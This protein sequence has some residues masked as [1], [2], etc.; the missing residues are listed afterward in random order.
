MISIS[1]KV[2]RVANKNTVSELVKSK[3]I[4]RL[5]GEKCLSVRLHMLRGS[6]KTRGVTSIFDG[7][8]KHTRTVRYG[9]EK[10]QKIKKQ[11]H[12]RSPARRYVSPS[13]F[14]SRTH[15]PLPA[16]QDPRK[17][18]DFLTDQ[19]GPRFFLR[20]FDPTVPFGNP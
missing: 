9:R 3:K 6:R 8:R 12:Y 5:P 4:T 10:K 16:L 19:C 11:R 13:P 18:R 2:S 7:G 1:S 14:L 15:T 20:F 17:P